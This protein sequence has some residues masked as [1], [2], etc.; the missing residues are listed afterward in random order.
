MRTL[1]PV[2]H[3]ADGQAS[4]GLPTLRP[5]MQAAIR[6]TVPPPHAGAEKESEGQGEGGLR[7]DLGGGGA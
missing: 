3:E 4:A 6:D 7:P 5:C 2:L 1:R